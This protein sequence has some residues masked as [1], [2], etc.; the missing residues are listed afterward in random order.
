MIIDTRKI[1]EKYKSIPRPFKI[2]L[3]HV[4]ERVKEE[5]SKY[6]LLILN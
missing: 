1:I 5:N 6:K 2:I 4:C 3:P